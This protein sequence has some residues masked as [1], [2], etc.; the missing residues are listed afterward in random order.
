MKW[1]VYGLNGWIGSYLRPLLPGEVI[2][3]LSRADNWTEVEKEILEHHP[4]RLVSLIGRTSGPGFSTIDYL[5]QP[6]KLVENIRDNLYGPLILAELA[7]IHGIHFTYLG[8]GCIFTYGDQIPE[9]CDE[10]D[11]PTFFGSGY[12]IVKGFTDRWFHHQS[13]VL[14]VRIRMPIVAETHSK[15][16]ITKIL[17]YPKILSTLN[18]MTV[19]PDLLPVMVEKMISGDTGT[20]NLVNPG[21]MS[22]NEILELYRDV[23]DSNFKWINFSESEHD[24]I[25]AAKRSKCVLDSSEMAARGVPTL[26]ESLTSIFLK[27]RN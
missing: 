17:N 15:N 6:G 19:L 23:V 8:T 2:V 22:H 4:D 13:H 21:P 1:L 5:E 9:P 11:E 10:N 3:G 27:T 26:R 12:S 7:K 24:S 16:F 25:L 18:S 14:N 20:V